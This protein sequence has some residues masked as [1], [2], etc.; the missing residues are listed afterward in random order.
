MPNTRCSCCCCC[1]SLFL[2]PWQHCSLLFKAC[3]SRLQLLSLS[4]LPQTLFNPMAAFFAAVHNLLL[5]TAVVI[6]AAPASCHP[7]GSIF[8]YCLK[9]AAPDCSR[10]RCCPRPCCPYLGS[11]QTACSASSSDAAKS[12]SRA[13]AAERLLNSTAVALG[14]SHRRNAI[15]T[16]QGRTVSGPGAF[17]RCHLRNRAQAE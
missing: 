16:A 2:S 15:C 11:R 13:W 3:C 14:E 8:R 12:P 5:Q 4:Q 10:Y 6:V 7:H 17:N 9:P 1:P